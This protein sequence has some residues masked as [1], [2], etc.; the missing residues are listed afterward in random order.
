MLYPGNVDEGDIATP[1][2]QDGTRLDGS[3]DE[4]LLVRRPELRTELGDQSERLRR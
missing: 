4:A 2:E 1:V 3:M